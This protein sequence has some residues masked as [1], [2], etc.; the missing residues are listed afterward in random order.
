MIDTYHE[1][2][3]R[4]ENPPSQLF[5]DGSS[6][7]LLRITAD[8]TPNEITM[9]F[10][11][12]RYFDS[13]DTSDIMGYEAAL[14]TLASQSRAFPNR[15]IKLLKSPYRRWIGD[16]FNFRDR[17]VIPG[18]CTLTIRKSKSGPTF[19][20]HER[21]ADKVA[22][23]Q[24]VTHVTPAGEFQPKDLSATANAADLDL[25][26]NIIREFAEEFLGIEHA[27][28]QPIDLHEDDRL[29]AAVST[30]RDGYR[31]D[32][33]TVRFLGVGLDPLT[34]KPEI[35]TVAIFEDEFFDKVFR[36]IVEMNDEGQLIFQD[37]RYR[38]GIPFT[39][40]NIEHRATGRMLMSGK[41]CLRLAWRHREHLG[42]S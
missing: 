9:H 25:L 22:L 10:G 6:Y 16:P 17:C 5:F 31:S 35:L 23:A 39:Y 2:I 34:W 40:E 15:R 28:G 26:S 18:V 37:S 4:V 11:P 20:L 33:Y 27:Q 41:A 7:R 19:I 13:L 32:R 38:A 14:C 42:L 30:L 12:G 24:G 21:N 8:T 1:M 29:R 3:Q 36:D